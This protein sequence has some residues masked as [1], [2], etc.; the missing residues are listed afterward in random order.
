MRD[1]VVILFVLFASFSF[2]QNFEGK[3]TFKVTYENLDE[4]DTTGISDTDELTEFIKK[5]RWR[6]DQN[7]NLG[8]QRALFNRT[9]STY[10]ILLTFSNKNLAIKMSKEYMQVTK[11]PEI[12]YKWRLRKKKVAGY[13][14]KLALI[15][16]P[17]SKPIKVYYTTRIEPAFNQK[18]EGLKGYPLIFSFLLDNKIMHHEAILIDEKK[19]SDK[20]FEIPEG[21]DVMT[22]DQFQNSLQH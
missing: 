2:G 11:A 3:V 22:M 14:C 18:F 20:T 16:Y 10:Y 4:K 12:K 6:S 1:S 19:L 8:T 21:Y 15:T 13:K 17:D 9:D 5:D 7:S